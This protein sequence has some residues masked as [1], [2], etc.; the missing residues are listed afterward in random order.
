ME[1]RP[2]FFARCAV[3]LISPAFS[4]SPP[5]GAVGWRHYGVKLRRLERDSPPHD[6]LPSVSSVASL[7]W[8]RP[9]RWN[10]ESSGQSMELF[11]S[12]RLVSP[13]PIWPGIRIACATP[14]GDV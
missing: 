14:A 4:M 9:F 2:H 7:D 13:L 3:Y 5:P 8:A 12:R 6:R 1:E 10:R 11:R